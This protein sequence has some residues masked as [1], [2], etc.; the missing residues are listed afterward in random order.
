MSL[1]TGASL[2]TLSLLLNK[3]SGLYGLLALLTGYDLSPVQLSMYL[4]SLIALGLTALLFPHIRK[5]SPLQCLTLAWL[6]VFDS[7]INAAYTAA[8]GVTWFLVISQHYENGHATGPGAETMAQTA[9]FTSPEPDTPLSGAGGDHYARSRN[10]VTQ[11]ESFQSIVFICILWLIRAYFVFVMLAFARQALRRYVAVPRHTQ[12]PTHSRNT[13]IASVASVADIDREPF[14]PYSPDGQGWKGKLGR[15]MI[16][17]NRNYWLG[18]DEEGGNWMSNLGRRFRAREE[19]TELTGPL[20]R[21]RRRRSGTGPPVPSQS[22]V[23]AALQPPA[24]GMNVKVH[25]WAE[26]R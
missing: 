14:S 7:V 12:L 17:I 13:S 2:I 5:Q 24:P 4:Y 19:A 15:A 18:E 10:A 8:F 9:G 6:Y 22:T 23:Q 25:D 11:P 26:T 21:E 16:S 20:E 1:Q 3:I